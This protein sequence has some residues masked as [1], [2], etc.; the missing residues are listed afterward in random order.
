MGFQQSRTPVIYDIYQK[1]CDA[2]G[3]DTL[4]TDTIRGLLSELALLEV[5]ESNQDH[6]GMGK[7]TYKEHRLLWEP[8]VVF[9]MDPDPA[10]VVQI[11]SVSTTAEADD[12]WHEPP[13]NSPAS[14]LMLN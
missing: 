7:G 14:L 6:G 2:E 3:T 8:S 11:N 13:R 1:V 10:H 12:F 9:K 5:T 4:T